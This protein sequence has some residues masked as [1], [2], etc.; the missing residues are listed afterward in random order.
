[1]QNRTFN[2]VKQ[3]RLP[4]N[5]FDLTHSKNI[6]L[7]H[8]QLVPSLLV[9]LLPGEDIT[10]KASSLIRYSPLIAPIMH[11]VN[12]YMHYFFVPHRLLWDDFE[13]F[14][15]GGENGQ[16]NTVWANLKWNTGP[17]FKARSLSDYL[18]LPTGNQVGGSPQELVSSLPFAT[19]QKIY[20]D[21]YRDQNLEAEVNFKVPSGTMGGGSALNNLVKL[22]ER[23]WQHDY[24]T[25]ALPWTQRGPE[26][27]LPLG[28]RA[29]IVFDPIDGKTQ[30]VRDINTLDPYF[31][32]NLGT[33]VS[34][35]QLADRNVVGRPKILLDL[36]ESHYADLSTATASSITDLR[37]AFKLQEWLEKQA[38]GGARYFESNEV[39]FGEDS[40]DARLQRAEY[41][42]GSK[43]PVKVSEVL[44]NSA[45]DS[46][47]TPQ[48][49]M[50]GHA[51]SAGSGGR[52]SYHAPEHGYVM[53][54]MSVMP[55]SAY[56]QGIPRQFSRRDKF[57]YYWKEFAH[58]G[59]QGIEN[60]ELYVS[61]VRGGDQN[62]ETFG[63]TPRYAEYKFINDSVHGDFRTSLDFW[64]MARN[65]SGLPP[66]DNDFIKMKQYEVD[67][68]F[69][70]Q[71]SADNKLWCHLLNEV[72][73]KRPMPIFANPKM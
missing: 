57:D 72:K 70:V 50:T 38:R 31:D 4:K 24:F 40:P 28:Q 42:G 68:I 23:A 71:D 5:T 48:G 6:S 54:I 35:G 3:D 16:D 63:Y 39:N 69:A 53:G 41:I 44:Q 25:S 20:N 13:N 59:E 36:N 29:D 15:T 14:I 10:I 47:T 55:E 43:V 49:T 17:A 46:T 32:A 26:A 7:D 51:I 33:D 8:G 1:M 9:D 61:D 27:M 56:S 18:G 58:I 30:Q 64:H 2:Q 19:Y 34:D 60:Q 67:R 21:Y 22:R 66:L 11:R 37:R 73:V 52:M 12:V 45:T 62:H 65:F